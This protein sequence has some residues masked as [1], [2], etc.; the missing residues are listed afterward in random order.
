MQIKISV[1]TPVYNAGK[2][3]EQCA[4]SLFGQ[5]LSEM[6]FIFVNDGTPDDSMTILRRVVKDYP[7]RIVKI[8]DLDK[9]QGIANARNLGL[10]NAT[11]EYVGFVDSDDWVDADMFGSL[12]EYAHGKDIC[13]CDFINEYKNC[14]DIARQQYGIDMH[15]NLHR[16]LD[17]TIFPSLWSEIVKRELYQKGKFRFTPGLNVAEDLY[18]NVCLFIEANEIVHCAKPFYHY[19]HTGDSITSSNNIK[20]IECGIRITKMIED[21]IREKSLYEQLK[22]SLLHREFYQK[23]ALWTI[24][25]DARNWR[26]TFPE[27]HRNI[28]SLKGFDWKTKMECW[29][30]ARHLPSVAIA[31]SR[32]LAWQSK[33]REA[34]HRSL[35]LI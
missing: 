18:A 17:G 22:P 19:R 33:A 8:I 15:E 30:V 20:N 16:L 9:N 25:H 27:S 4:R 1:I 3:I 10:D 29:L 5:T 12:Y 32:F 31:F 11:G 13:A 34:F 21:K 14:S 6:E 24:F 7:E 35:N 2:Y 28:F 23:R 26:N